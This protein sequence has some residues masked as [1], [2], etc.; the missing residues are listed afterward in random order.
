MECER[1]DKG[2]CP[3]P[4]WTEKQMRRRGEPQR[5]KL[6]RENPEGSNIGEKKDI[7][8]GGPEEA[9]R[10]KAQSEGAHT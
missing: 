2:T 3:R 5:K 9:S 10:K 8:Q 4:D 1:L 7:A 6:R